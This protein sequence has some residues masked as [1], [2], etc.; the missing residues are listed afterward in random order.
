MSVLWIEGF[1]S[2]GTSGAA[3]GLQSKYTGNVFANMDVDSPRF[4]GYSLRLRG[5]GGQNGY[6]TTPNLGN[7]ATICTGFSYYPRTLLN[8]YIV[9]LREADNSTS[10]M[11]IRMQTDGK[12]SLYRNNTLIATTAISVLSAATWHHIELKVTIANSGTYELRVNG[13]N[14]LSG[15]ADTREGS[16]DYCNR[17]RLVG[18]DAIVGQAPS[19]DDWWIADAF[20]GDRKVMTIF[21]DADGDSS[22]FT[23]STGGDNYAMVDDN[24]PD[25]DSTY[26]QSDTPGDSDLYTHGNVSGA[27]SIIAIQANIVA[28]KTDVTDFDM[29]LTVKSGSTEDDG[30]A[31]TV[32]STDFANYTRILETDPDT[33]VAWT[34]SGLNS[35]QIGPKVG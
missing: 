5:G 20:L 7:V 27:S 11:N 28:R 12:I 30:A 35:A 32:S 1:D 13:V 23:P 18:P 15:S 31:V 25:D 17:V 6:I 2:F 26:V 3:V 8:A 33:G 19:F 21:P 24:G 10:G 22:D 14:V 16:N 34:Q 4:T 29:N 9:E